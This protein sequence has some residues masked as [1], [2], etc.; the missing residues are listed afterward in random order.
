MSS[1]FTWDPD[2]EEL[3]DAVFEHIADRLTDL[4]FND[5]YADSEEYDISDFAYAMVYD[6]HYYESTYL[7]DL[8][9]M[10]PGCAKVLRLLYGY[11]K[12]S[13]SAPRQASV[14]RAV[15]KKPA[16]KSCASKPKS[17]TPAKK[18]PAKKTK[19]ARR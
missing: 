9:E 12:Y 15:A 8:A 10:D 7:K 14:R 1:R 6:R 18:A 19:G 4:G 3:R 11:E 16:S 17:K 2:S 13:E 5:E